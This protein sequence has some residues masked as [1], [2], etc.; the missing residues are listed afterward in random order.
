MIAKT[1]SEFPFKVSKKR[2]TQNYCFQKP[3]WLLFSGSSPDYWTNYFN[4]I[5]ISTNI[6]NK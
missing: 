4:D 6:D 1:K 3:G 2:L 5:T